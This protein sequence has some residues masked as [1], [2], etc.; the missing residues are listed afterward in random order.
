MHFGRASG[1]PTR[2]VLIEEFLTG[3]ELSVFILTDGKNYVLLPEA[4][5]YKRIGDGDEGPNT[6]GM[7]AVSPVPFANSVFMEKVRTQIIE[8]TLSGLEKEN[9]PYKG[10][11]FFGLI[12][13]GDEPFV[14]EYNARMGDP[15][16]EAVVPR[17]QTDLVQLLMACAKGSLDNS[18]IDISP[19]HAVTVVMV[20]GGYPGEY[21]IG[22]EIV[23]LE[24]QTNALCFHA[25]TTGTDQR[26]Y[27]NGGRVLAVTATGADIQ[28]ARTSAYQSI[29][30]ISYAGMYFRKDIGVDLL[31]IEK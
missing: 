24:Q 18:S 5:D 9:I 22:K 25:G 20:S 29:S 10:F 31:Q 16:S 13:V 17:I 26:I 1:W 27:T 23:G 12:K 6:G 8:P 28:E 2:L 14:I 3:M 19:E 21:S 30:G 15:E 11:I 4:K 7:G